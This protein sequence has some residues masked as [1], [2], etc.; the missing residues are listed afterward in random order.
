MA[1][2]GFAG[3]VCCLVVQMGADLNRSKVFT[4]LTVASIR[5]KLSISDP[6]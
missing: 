6:L 1:F 4:K 2:A 5:R 3:F